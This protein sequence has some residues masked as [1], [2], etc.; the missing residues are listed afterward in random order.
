MSTG[1]ELFEKRAERY[2][3]DKYE[4]FLKKAG[5]A[6]SSAFFLNTRKTERE[7]ILGLIDFPVWESKYTSDSFL[8]HEAN[9]GKTMPYDLGLIYPQDTAASLTGK[10]LEE[11][12]ADLVLDLCA[13]PGGKSIDC[14]NRAE[15][16]CLIA[17]DVSYE[18]AKTISEN[19]ERLGIG[20]AVITSKDPHELCAV[21]EE[22]ADV[23]ILDVPCSGEGMIRKYPEILDTY[24]E[25]GIE[26][27]AAIQKDLLEDAYLALAKDGILLYSTCT[28]A[29]EEDEDQIT[30]FL[31]RHPDMELIHQDVIGNASVLP[32][33]VKLSFLNDT[34]G[35]FF[36]AMK[37]TSGEK[38]RFKPLKTAKEKNVSAFLKEMLDIEVPYVYEHN[39]VYSLSFTPLPDLG[40]G[41]LRYG[42][43][44]GSMGPKR[45]EPA[46][47]FFRDAALQPHYRK[48]AEL[49]REEVLRYLSGEELPK[50]GEEGITCVTYEGISLGYGNLRKGRLKNK[51]PKGLRRML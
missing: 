11:R 22:C 14:V 47:H 9:I 28:F 32:G 38:R 20:N 44:I 3:G 31:E 12:K 33:C 30:G 16:S 46:H 23:V 19:F 51:Y 7:K 25:N 42:T 26:R 13:A 29:F 48:T 35:Q 18:R 27:L 2:F 45:F 36:A 1:R 49:S 40:K 15:V 21:L 39:G 50:E 4:I 6:P 17:N 8:H 24:S 43:Q 41:V 10:I 37:K 5:K 34:E